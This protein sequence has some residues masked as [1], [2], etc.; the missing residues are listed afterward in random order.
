MGVLLIVAVVL[1]ALVNKLPGMV[2]GSLRAQAS[3]AASARPA[4]A[5]R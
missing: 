1:L 5:R 2:S 3:A 4:L